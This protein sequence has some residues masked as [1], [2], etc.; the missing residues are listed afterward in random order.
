SFTKPYSDATAQTIDHEVR[1]LIEKQYKRSK[2]LLSKKKGELE[3]LANE[4]LK[5]EII[6]QSDLERLIG[7]RPF[8]KPTTYE[9]FTNGESSKEETT[10]SAG[11]VESTAKENDKPVAKA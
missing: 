10:E 1:E 9:A 11:K 4:L 5:K 6:F 7:K 2:V 8:A 3:I